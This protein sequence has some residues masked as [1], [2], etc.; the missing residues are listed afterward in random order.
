MTLARAPT[1]LTLLPLSDHYAEV[2]RILLL[3]SFVSL[4][5]APGAGQAASFTGLGLGPSGTGSFAAGVS[6]DGSVVV[7]TTAQLHSFRWTPTGG[8]VD[9]G[10]LPGVPSGGAQIS[11]GYAVSA[12]GSVLVSD[13]SSASGIQAFRWTL[14]GGMLGLG[15]LP[16]LNL[17]SG[18]GV[19]A[20]GIPDVVTA[21]AVFSGGKTKI[22]RQLAELAPTA[23]TQ[24]SD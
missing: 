12:D 9:L 11:T 14:A 17:S 16:G 1:V 10:F 22:V 13:S 18:H 8:M 15:F 20:D 3:L 5:A 19:S 4:A 7:G 23:S 2:W 6:A 24:I 21:G